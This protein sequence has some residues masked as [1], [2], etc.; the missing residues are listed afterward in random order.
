MSSCPPASMAGRAVST[1]LATT[2]A[3]S[4]LYFRSSIQQE[5]IAALTDGKLPLSDSTVPF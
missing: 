3:S 1:A 4:I 5:R 2:S